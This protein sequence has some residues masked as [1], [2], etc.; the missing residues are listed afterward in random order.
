MAQPYQVVWYPC[1][2]KSISTIVGSTASL[3]PT[4][5]SVDQMLFNFINWETDTPVVLIAFGILLAPLFLYTGWRY[6]VRQAEAVIVKLVN[7]L[8]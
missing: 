7:Q 6:I 4:L 3:L 5:L 2:R 8:Y 1:G